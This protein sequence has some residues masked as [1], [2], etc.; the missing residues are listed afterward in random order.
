M[1]LGSTV[2]PAC[3]NSCLEKEYCAVV[4]R[5][6]AEDPIG[7]APAHKRYVLVE[8]PLPW[9]PQVEE[10]RFFPQGLNETLQH[11]AAAGA[12]ARFLA[13]YSERE[14]SPRGFH[15][16]FVYERE[17]AASARFA[18]KE[19]IMAEAELCAFVEALLLDREEE[20]KRFDRLLLKERSERQHLFICTHG[21]HDHCCGVFGVPLYRSLLERLA[22][23]EAGVWRTSH[24]GGHRH[25]PT[26]IA[27]PAG[28][29]WAQV[30]EETAVSIIRRNVP[31]G[32]LARHYRGWGGVE[33][34]AQIA[35]RE[36]FRSEGWAWA[37]YVKEAWFVTRTEKAA[38]IRLAFHSPDGRHSGEYEVEIVAAGTVITG[39]CGYG[40]GE[41]KQWEV[42]AVS[43]ARSKK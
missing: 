35:E 39:G 15:R 32:Q 19:Y 7:S 28:T 13:C 1:N 30:S 36:A 12:K 31:F 40:K 22:V 20:Q 29:Y 24:F 8:V 38:T 17:A 26:L 21:S 11:C 2:V 41:A 6:G 4:S 10:S 33:G 16:V 43:K 9:S 14:A 37:D 25:A 27:F 23:D 3:E 34:L 18:S 42:V 5:N